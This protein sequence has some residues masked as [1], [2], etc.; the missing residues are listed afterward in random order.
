MLN[1]S[2]SNY[3]HVV[4]FSWK[5]EGLKFIFKYNMKAIATY[6]IN[7]MLIIANK[8]MSGN[9]CEPEDPCGLAEG[10]C[11]WNADCMGELECGRS[12]CKNE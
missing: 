7:I 11:D 3:V 8:C 5:L 10:D 2:S 4:F 9:C 12:N 6:L 1:H